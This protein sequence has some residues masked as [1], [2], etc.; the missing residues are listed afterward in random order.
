M[1]L[2]Y[3]KRDLPGVAP[4]DEL[5]DALNYRGV[6]A[7]AAATINGEG[8]FETLKSASQLVLQS[9]SRRFRAGVTQ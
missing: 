9:L 6:P 3:N 5:D 7:F 8:V 1:V 4:V 2:Q